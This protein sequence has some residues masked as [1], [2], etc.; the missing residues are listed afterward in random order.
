MFQG[1]FMVNDESMGEEGDQGQFTQMATSIGN[2]PDKSMGQ[3]PLTI[4]Y[5]RN[6]LKAG[7]TSYKQR[8]TAAIFFFLSKLDLKQ[9]IA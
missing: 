5:E 2:L 7:I 1:Q 9:G 6:I 4:T 8:E 3:G